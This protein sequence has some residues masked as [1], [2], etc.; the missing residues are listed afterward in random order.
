MKSSQLRAKLEA[1]EQQY[2]DL[3]V[4]TEGCDC[5]G[6]SGDV[7]FDTYGECFYIERGT[8]EEKEA[9]AER[10]RL[11]REAVVQRDK[12]LAEQYPGMLP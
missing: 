11:Q 2:G 3:E 10:L 8:P 5:N 7:V 9:E 12:E 4:V 1:L 6:D